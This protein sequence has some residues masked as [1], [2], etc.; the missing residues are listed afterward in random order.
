MVVAPQRWDERGRRVKTDR[1]DAR[2]RCARLD[3]FV[4]GNAA[5]F[6]VVRVPTPEQERQ[7]ALCRQRGAVLQ[8]R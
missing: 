4:R 7:R 3:R 2:E 6:A 5:V 8:E 1:R